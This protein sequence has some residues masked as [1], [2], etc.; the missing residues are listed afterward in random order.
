[1]TAKKPR[2]SLSKN[3]PSMPKWEKDA[4]A[5]RYRR[6]LKARPTTKKRKKG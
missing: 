5:E 1:M 4:K 6:R 3:G 2:S